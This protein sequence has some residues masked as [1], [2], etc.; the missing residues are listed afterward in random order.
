MPE[1]LISP[2]LLTPGGL[3]LIGGATKVGKSDFLINFLI[4]MAAGEPFLG[5]KPP[6]PLRIFYLQA[7]IGYHYMRE[8][9]KKLKVSKET[10][11][12]AS[13]NL[14]ST[15][16]IQ[17]ILNDNGVDTVYKLSLIHISEPTRPY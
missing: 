1:D 7:E 10:I 17:M 15:T 14:V 8:R 2:R 11:A 16:N 3:L 13:D 4:H 12:K 6:R 5:L 9:I